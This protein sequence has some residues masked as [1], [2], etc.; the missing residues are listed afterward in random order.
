M[1]LS[2]VSFG[3]GL[4]VW[5]IWVFIMMLRLVNAGFARFQHC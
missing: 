2:Q 4:D 3:V 1:I 5:Q